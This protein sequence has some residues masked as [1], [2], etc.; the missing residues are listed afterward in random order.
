MTAFHRIPWRLCL[1]SGPEGRKAEVVVPLMARRK[2]GP[3]IC[4]YNLSSSI[5]LPGHPDEWPSDLLHRSIKEAWATQRMRLLLAVLVT[6][7]CA[8][9]QNTKYAPKSQQLPGPEKAADFQVW[10]SDIQ[11]WR[12]GRLL[13]IGCD[14]SQYE[15]GTKN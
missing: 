6:L 13:Q 8:C 1:P 12:R 7:A 10:L 9:A 3:D 14:G 2:P 4:H 11:H 15:T 5:G